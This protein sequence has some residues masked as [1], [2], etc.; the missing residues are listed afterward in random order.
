MQWHYTHL[1]PV[2]LITGLLSLGIAIFAWKQ[3]PTRGAV[4]FAIFMTVVVWWT[5]FYASEVAAIT[6]PA[7]L[8]SNAL[9]FVGIVAV[10]PAWLLF[11]LDYANLRH[12]SSGWRRALLLTIPLL[13]LVQVWT[14]DYHRLFRTQAH[15]ADLGW[16]TNLSMEYGPGFYIHIAYFYLLVLAGAVL[17]TRQNFS[18]PRI[19]RGQKIIVLTS[20][21]LPWAVNVI[22]ISRLIP[23]LGIDLTPFALA[24]S[25]LGLAWAIF[26]FRLS[27]LIPIARA[28]VIDSLSDGVIVLD[29]QHRIQ[30]INPALSA[31]LELPASR[32]LGVP[33]D[34]RLAQWPRIWEVLRGVGKGQLELTLANSQ[35]QRSFDCTISRLA[36]RAGRVSGH[37]LV[38]KDITPYKQSQ[39]YLER[40]T[41]HLEMFNEIIAGATAG[42]NLDELLKMVLQKVLNTLKVEFGCLDLFE[43]RAAHNMSETALNCLRALDQKIDFNSLHFLAVKDWQVE[44]RS[45][46]QGFSPDFKK[47]GIR[48]LLVTPVYFD[49]KIIGRFAIL[50]STPRSWSAEEIALLD[51]IG[52]QLGAA[53]ERL[54]QQEKVQ[55]HNQLLT[56]LVARSESFSRQLTTDEILAAIS[57]GA[58]TLCQA[59]RVHIFWNVEDTDA[60]FSV[61]TTP[62]AESDLPQS[63]SSLQAEAASAEIDPLTAVHLQRTRPRALAEPVLIADVQQVKQQGQDLDVVVDYR[64]MGMWPLVYEGQTIAL[65]GVYFNDRPHFWSEPEREIMRAFTHQAATALESARLYDNLQKQVAETRL[66]YRALTKLFAP[67]ENLVSLAQHICQAVVDEFGAAHCGVLLANEETRRM[68]ILAQAGYTLDLYPIMLD[69]MGLTILAYHTDTIIYAPDVSKNPRYCKGCEQTRSEAVFPLRVRGRTVGILNIESPQLDAFDESVRRVMSAFTEQAALALENARLFDLANVQMHQMENLNLITQTALTAPDYPAML[70]YL[71]DYLRKLFSADDCYITAWDAERKR[72]LPG[73]ASGSTKD[74]FLNLQVETGETSLTA[75]ILHTGQPVA[76]EDV[77]TSPYVNSRLVRQFPARSILGLPLIAKEK[78]IGAA[79]VAYSQLHHFLPEEL[80]LGEQASA[81]I[82]LAIANAHS[83]EN[84]RQR[85]QEA[86]NLRQAAAAITSGLDLENILNSILEHVEQVVPFDSAGVFLKDGDLLHSVATKGLP[87]PEQVNGL[88]FPSDNVFMQQLFSES[89]PLVIANINQDPR[90]RA[91]GGTDYVRGWMGV[92][93][94]ASNKVIGCL[95]LDSYLPDA[96]DQEKASLVQAFANQA[97]AAIENA[98]LFSE[99]ERLAV[100][101][102]LTGLLNRRGYTTLAQREIERSRRFKRTL[103]VILLDI[104]HFKEVND[105]YKHSI[106]DQVLIEVAERCKQKTRE[107]DISGRYGGEELVV[108]LPETDLKGAMTF[109]EH[110]RQHVADAPFQ[111]TVGPLPIT[112]S[113]GISVSVNGKT[114]LAELIEQADQ[115]MYAAKQAGRNCARAYSK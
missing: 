109:A 43:Y 79:L 32:L 34:Q 26:G 63:A 114:N 55:A 17:I 50:D 49:E 14:A 38:L 96:Y 95:T 101:D 78:K 39:A 23:W 31:I 90:W 22:Y 72:G 2:L 91:W 71:V 19:F 74:I 1:I 36:D 87:H 77:Q 94:I 67:G 44:N 59:D 75:M 97:A 29:A 40:R 100:T 112:I 8:L 73:A 69:G 58:Q 76:V 110:L 9:V 61:L 56:L 24:F 102:P 4:S 27:N 106:G 99:V 111:T 46:W 81:L 35:G 7:R 54:Q 93:L 28:T 66:L 83:L 10:P 80:A 15:I 6:L 37:V 108:F 12:W 105:T 68:D 64:A 113:L 41:A 25:G 48:S 88:A 3:R 30:A 13:T 11:S 103:S 47:V 107:I 115:A 5:V 33:A 92:P 16:I 104:D 89:R 18:V 65:V 84:S 45:P 82:A 60:V 57:Q 98:R 85:A 51:S 86:E 20:V 62:G 21:T 70:Q 53:A 52:K 42:K